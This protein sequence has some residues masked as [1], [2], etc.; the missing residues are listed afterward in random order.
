MST[1]HTAPA[2]Q[3]TATMPAM[4]RAATLNPTSFDE[5]RRTVEVVWTTGAVVPRYDWRNERAY[6]EELV[7]DAQ[8]VDLDR[9]NAGASVLDTHDQYNLSSVIGVVERAWLDG[10]EGRATVR[11]SERPELAG[12]VADIKAGVIRHISAGY[13]VQRVEMVPPDARTDGG[14]RWLYRATRWQPAEI[15]FVPVPADAGSGTRS[16]PHG[17]TPCE[18][19]TRAAAQITQEETPMSQDLTGG[20]NN[21]P[22]TP[23]ATAPGVDAAAIATQAAQR[24]ADISDLCSRH[25]VPELASELIR[26]GADLAAAQAKVLDKIAHRDAAAGGHQNVRSVQTVADE[27]ATRMKGVEQALQHRLDP[28]VKLDDN[29]RRFRSVPLLELGRGYLESRG[30]NT[31]AMDK[32]GLAHA[33]MAT[34]ATPTPITAWN[35]SADFPGIMANVA[36]K[37]LRDAYNED[38]G[39]YTVWA[40]RAPNAPDFKQISVAQLSGAPNLQQVNEAGEY[41]YGTLTDGA[42][43]YQVMT[44]GKIVALTRQAIVNDDLRAFDGLVTAFGGAARRKEN[45]LVY[46]QLTAAGNYSA[47]NGNLGA[48][49]LSFEALAAMRV[50]MRKQ[51]GLAGEKLNLSASFLIVPP[52]LWSIADQLT[53]STYVPAVQANISEFR[54]GG[55]SA[56]T[57]VVEALLSDTGPATWYA[58]A[59]GRMVDTVEYCYLDG[60]EGPVT[61]S[62]TGWEID[63]MEMKV[64]LDFAAKAIDHRGLYKSVG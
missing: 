25:A 33:M 50:A 46:A 58:A 12:L 61:E 7:V 38:P 56:L 4:V 47:P 35:D 37:R 18:F 52:E 55:R 14:A 32:M 1:P 49:A 23:A 36:N 39:T 21:T 34:R 48:A 62:K 64:R 57:P 26:S 16:Q 41:T 20:A 8:A 27:F 59:G 51:T 9:M 24:A 3:T 54:A 2:L 31:N 17:G 28:S 40:R 45:E 53:S 15:S 30:I 10:T 19:T 63:G 42:V 60:A 11:L 6:D 44:Y 5:T 13:S 43:N 22:A 29:G